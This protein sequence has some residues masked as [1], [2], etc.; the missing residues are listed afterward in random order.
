MKAKVKA[1]KKETELLQLIQKDLQLV[2]TELTT[3]ELLEKNAIRDF[4]TK[5][6]KGLIDSDFNRLIQVMYRLDISESAFRTALNSPNPDEVA[7][8]IADLVIERE[9]LKIKS[10]EY[11]S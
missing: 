3:R 9:L 5:A 6:I 11:Y 1:K 7:P 2:Q 10:R 8:G 4:L